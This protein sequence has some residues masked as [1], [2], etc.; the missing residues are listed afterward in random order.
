VVPRTDVPCVLNRHKVD[1]LYYKSVYERDGRIKKFRWQNDLVRLYRAE[2]RARRRY[3]G[4]VMCSRVDLNRLIAIAGRAPARVVP[5]GVD[6]DFFQPA[7]SEAGDRRTL[8]FVGTMDYPPNID[9]ARWF[10]AEIWPLLRQKAPDVE[11]LF[12]GHRPAP[13]VL[14]LG[15]T[16]GITVTGGVDDVRP[17]LRDASAVIVPVR[18]GEGT[19]L[20]ILE[21]MA[22]ERPVIST[23]TGA[24]G[25]R[26]KDGGHLHLA[27]D[28]SE[29]ITRTLSVLV[30]PAEAAEIAAA[31]RRLVL[32][33][34]GWDVI[35]AELLDFYDEVKSTHGA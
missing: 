10:A 13:E 33:R 35:A 31:G 34:Y 25:L 23:R 6:L 4:H 21:A 24:E 2:R 14:A 5:N 28:E 18:I 26:V 20:K 17:Y 30:D 16:P 22:M 8:V 3:H 9:A 7:P 29:F 1:T 15:E 12:V 19:R 11:A 27:R 32:E